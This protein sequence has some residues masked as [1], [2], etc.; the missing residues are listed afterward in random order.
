MTCT[1]KSQEVSAAADCCCHDAVMRC[2]Y[3]WLQHD[4]DGFGV[5]EILDTEKHVNI[6]TTF[7]N[8][9]T[10]RSHH[11]HTHNSSTVSIPSHQFGLQSSS[12]PPSALL[13]PTDASGAVQKERWV[14]HVELQPMDG[15]KK[16]REN[17]SIN[18]VWYVAL[19]QGNAQSARI[20][21]GLTGV[22]E[23]VK[24]EIDTGKGEVHTR[25][26]GW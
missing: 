14:A 25:H 20:V 23:N 1:S 21:Q 2:R 6:T 26:T 19:E 17:V 5:Q 18:L 15:K 10:H 7:I 13:Q 3:G 11:H 12:P 22:R 4:G 9:S 24:V 8:V 16:K